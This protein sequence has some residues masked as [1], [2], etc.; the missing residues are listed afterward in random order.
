MKMI[1]QGA[2]NNAHKIGYLMRFVLR[3]YMYFPA[4]NFLVAWQQ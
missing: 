4:L 2:A 1:K 3:S